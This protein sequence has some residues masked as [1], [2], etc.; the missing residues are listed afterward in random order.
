[1]V[2]RACDASSTSKTFEYNSWDALM[3]T[4]TERRE[5]LT[6]LGGTEAKYSV[7][8]KTAPHNK[9]LPFPE[10]RSA[11]EKDWRA[12]LICIIKILQGSPFTLWQI[13]DELL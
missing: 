3:V 6:L 7:M 5:L 13:S 8:H 9:G 1:M 4:I 2:F 12:V 11:L 10:S